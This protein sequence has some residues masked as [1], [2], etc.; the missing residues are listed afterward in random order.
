MEARVDHLNIHQ[1]A[2]KIPK[3]YSVVHFA[4]LWSHMPRLMPYA[5]YHQGN[6]LLVKPGW[7]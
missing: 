3:I 6:S 4:L 1:L 2:T 5:K 7:E